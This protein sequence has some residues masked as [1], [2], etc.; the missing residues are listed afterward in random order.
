[1]TIPIENLYYILAYAYRGRPEGG[2]AALGAVDAHAQADLL[3]HVLAVAV[4]GQIRRGLVRGYV[5]HAEDTASPRG[6]IDV[7]ETTRRALRLRGQVH[8]S[9]DEFVADVPANRLVL[10]TLRGLLRTDNVRPESRAA[11]RSVVPAFEGVARVPLDGHAFRT[12]DVH[13]GARPYRFLVELCALVYRGLLPTER[14][15]RYR[16]RDIT[17]DEV[18]MRKLFQQFVT[19]FFRREQHA[20]SV[21]SEK[22]FL[23]GLEPVGPSD[24]GLVPAMF[25]DIVLRDRGAERAILIDTKYTS[26]LAAR[27][28]ADRFK[29]GHLYQMA[30]Y[31]HHAP[32][33]LGPAEGV[34]LYPTVGRRLDETYRLG[35]HQL[36]VRTLDLGQP[37][38]SIHAALL[39]LLE[40][41]GSGEGLRPPAG[42]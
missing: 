40:K 37:W 2:V 7:G 31:L 34:L 15:G 3:A 11:I 20:F 19:E 28:G 24:P 5:G 30:A 21:E 42:V 38:L 26:A 22:R 9:V 13:A 23:W 25:V 17:R 6:R 27:Y 16:F 4:R 39:G 41:K 36:R 33:A 14:A 10:A 1:M 12:V 8:V 18:A 29:S 35:D 32:A